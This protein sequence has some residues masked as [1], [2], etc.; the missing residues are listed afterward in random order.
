[1]SLELVTIAT[2][3]DVVEAEFLRNQLEAEGFEVYLEDENI[4]GIFNLLAPAVGGI[5]IRVHADKAEEAT[6]LVNDLRNAEII[7]D[8]NFPET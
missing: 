5:K 3:Y 2:S 4:V 7:Y 1:M 6:A 8:E